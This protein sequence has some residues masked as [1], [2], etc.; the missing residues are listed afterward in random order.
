[1]GRR[2]AGHALGR[3]AEDAPQEHQQLSSALLGELSRGIA[4]LSI[5]QNRDDWETS[6]VSDTFSDLYSLYNGRKVP[7]SVINSKLQMLHEEL[8]ISMKKVKQVGTPLQLASSRHCKKRIGCTPSTQVAAPHEAVSASQLAAP[9][10]A[11]PE[12]NSLM[13]SDPHCWCLGPSHLAPLLL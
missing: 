10:S 9:A 2:K 5:N 8:G 1:M 3:I 6:S 11:C 4:G 7:L 13:C 12:T